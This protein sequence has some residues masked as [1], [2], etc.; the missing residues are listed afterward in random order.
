MQTI[1]TLLQP[2]IDRKMAKEVEAQDFQHQAE[3]IVLQE[4]HRIICTNYFLDSSLVAITI[5]TTTISAILATIILFMQTQKKH[6]M[7]YT[8]HL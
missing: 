6:R 4:S 8:N 2:K 5:T 7:E 1:S 3:Q